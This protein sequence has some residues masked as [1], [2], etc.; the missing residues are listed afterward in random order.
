M[1]QRPLH[2]IFTLVASMAITSCTIITGD[3]PVVEKTI[4]LEPFHSV[5]VDGSFDVEINQAAVQNVVV[6]TQENIMERF[7]MSVMDGVLYLSIEPGTYLSY[8]LTV[9]LAMP[10]VSSIELDGSGDVKIGTFVG[11]QDLSIKL[12]GSG[13]V[14]GTGA[15]EVLSEA[16]IDLQGS[17]DIELK[18]KAKAV[19]L[20][21]DGSGDL[22]VS[23]QTNRLI[24]S[25]N[26]S[27]DIDAA[28]LKSIDCEVDV[29]GS[30]SAKVYASEKLKATLQGSGDIRYDGKPDVEAKIDGSGTIQAD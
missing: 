4:E 2:A 30:G 7:K 5:H 12:D 1:F 29:N 16:T 24:A 28:D 20:I 3:G 23:G 19:E 9:K 15:V 8:D 21:L 13:D 25:L 22:E 18:L 14:K 11:L 27:G 6:A 10:T 26:G 17:G